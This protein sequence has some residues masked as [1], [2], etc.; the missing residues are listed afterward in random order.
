M[1]YICKE[2]F[3]NEY[4]K[5][6]K[7]HKV[8]DRCHYKQGYRGAMHSICNLKLSVSKKISM[9][10]HNGSNYDYDFIIKELA[11]Q[12]EKTIYLFTRKY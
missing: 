11:E 2:K 12:F 1:Y 7:Y 9:I 6:E 8:R 3:E 10:F 4:L 5:D